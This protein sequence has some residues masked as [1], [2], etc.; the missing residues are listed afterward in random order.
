MSFLRFT[1]MSGYLLLAISI[2]VSCFAFAEG[3]GASLFEAR[4]ASCHGASGKGKPSAKAPSLLS[5]KVKSLSDDSIRDLIASRANGE[6]EKKPV[7][8]SIK[9]RLTPE[10]VSAVVAHIRE[11]QKAE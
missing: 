1:K 5:D 3:D 10:Q 8:T 11:L 2:L 7:H 9:K 6:M 4:C